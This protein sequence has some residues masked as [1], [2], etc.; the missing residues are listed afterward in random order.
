MRKES[1]L[2]KALASL[3]LTDAVLLHL[4]RVCLAVGS[5]L[6]GLGA[7]GASAACERLDAAWVVVAEGCEVV[8]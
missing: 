1:S 8:D 2:F 6:V 3:K 4:R 5:I 7:I